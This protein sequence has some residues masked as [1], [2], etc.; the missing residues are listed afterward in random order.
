[1]KIREPSPQEELAF[2]SSALETLA[3]ATLEHGYFLRP[4]VIKIML[5]ITEGKDRILPSKLYQDAEQ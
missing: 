1:M 3:E 2:A 5:S 4:E